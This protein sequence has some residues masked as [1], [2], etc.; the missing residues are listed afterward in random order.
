MARKFRFY[1]T[2]VMNGCIVG[3]DDEQVA[4]EYAGL[5]ADA[6]VV[7]TQ[8]GTWLCLDADEGVI[9]MPVD[10]VKMEETEHPSEE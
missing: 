3:T 10:E 2:D 7:D 6:F 5:E 8:D 1:I 9:N 4:T